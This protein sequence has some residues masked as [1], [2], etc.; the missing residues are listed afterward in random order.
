MTDGRFRYQLTFMMERTF[1]RIHKIAIYD[2]KVVHDTKIWK[3]KVC[4]RQVVIQCPEPIRLQLTC[5]G[6]G[7]FEVYI[8]RESGPP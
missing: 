2:V 6:L 3:L 7:G 5:G 4:L 1:H 8:S